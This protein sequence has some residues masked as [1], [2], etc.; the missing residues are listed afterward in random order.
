[1]KEVMQLAL[2]PVSQSHHIELNVGN[3][4]A[5][6]LLSLLFYGAAT[7]SSN[8]LARTEIPVVSQVAVGAQMF[9]HAA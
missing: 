8:V 3:I 5:I 6:G 1:M 4:F 9:L 2:V 7:W